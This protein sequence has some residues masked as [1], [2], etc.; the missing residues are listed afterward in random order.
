[1]NEFGKEIWD[2]ITAL[3]WHLII[4]NLNL[5]KDFVYAIKGNYD[6]NFWQWIN[7]KSRMTIIM[8]IIIMYNH[9]RLVFWSKQVLTLSVWK[10]KKLSFLYTNLAGYVEHNPKK[11]SRLVTTKLWWF[12]TDR[13]VD[14]LRHKYFFRSE[15]YD[16]DSLRFV[17]RKGTVRSRNNRWC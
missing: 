4:P 5:K 2:Y 1:M 13:P 8:M 12:W 9:D 17:G 3:S 7:A 6:L 15:C 10:D 11:Q 14:S 16:G